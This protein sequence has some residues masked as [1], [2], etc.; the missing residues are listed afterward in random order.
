[1]QDFAGDEAWRAAGKAGDSKGGSAPAELMHDLGALAVPPAEPWRRRARTLLCGALSVLLHSSALAAMLM[2]NDPHTE[3]GAISVPS[4]AISVEIVS[5]SVLES[6]QQKEVNTE[7]AEA[8]TDSK[9]GAE[10]TQAS[11]KTS[12]VAPPEREPVKEAAEDSGKVAS[13]EMEIKEAAPQK[14][15]IVERQ[16]PKLLP[17]EPAPIVMQ[18]PPLTEPQPSES[19]GDKE[20]ARARETAEQARQEAQQRQERIEREARER[21][22]REREEERQRV[23]RKREAQR[24]EEEHKERQQ[25]KV[26][27][28]GA[29]SK[30]A[31]AAQSQSG[32]VSA[33]AGS[34]LTYASRIRAHV[35][36]HKPSGA[37]AQ[38]T[39]MVAFGVTTSGGLS[40]ASIS[41][42]SGNSSLD[43]LAVSAVRGAAPFPQPPVGASPG[44]LRFTIPFH[45]Q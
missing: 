41:K 40:Y 10:P 27:K 35:A 28:G 5:S 44:Q 8:A 2:L 6:M 29:T 7:A 26:E 43:R 20:A 37:G 36:S 25:K 9:A 4:Q 11:E 31:A 24:K 13:A 32:R 22:Q 21:R 23:E 30:A 45:F 16:M 38:G 17:D 39:A 12:K 14:T 1:V 34:I 33:S 42:S 19:D 15:D 3:L 18:P